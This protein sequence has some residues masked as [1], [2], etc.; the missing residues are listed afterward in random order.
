MGLFCSQSSSLSTLSRG[1]PESQG[2]AVSSRFA[3]TPTLHKLS[4]RNY[5]YSPCELG[6]LGLYFPVRLTTS[7]IS[8]AQ[9][10]RASGRAA[11]RMPRSRR[12]R[13]REGYA[14]GVT[15]AFLGSSEAARPPGQRTAARQL[16]WLVGR[17]VLKRPSF[18]S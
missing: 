1:W 6:Y 3:P 16:H 13:R 11:R 17:R 14:A 2:R 12:G 15:S 4:W 9:A 10:S 18:R 7:P 8:C 5:T